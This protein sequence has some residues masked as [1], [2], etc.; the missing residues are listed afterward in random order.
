MSTRRPPRI[1]TGTPTRARP[2]L[3]LVD[4]TRPEGVFDPADDW[5]SP[6]ASP[7]VRHE[8]RLGRG[9][10][11]RPTLRYGVP[12][13]QLEA[14]LPPALN[15]LRRTAPLS[16]PDLTRVPQPQH[17]HVM[18]LVDQLQSTTVVRDIENHIQTVRAFERVMRLND[19]DPSA[20][21]GRPVAETHGS[22]GPTPGVSILAVLVGFALVM[23]YTGRC[24]KKDIAEI[25]VYGLPLES[26]QSLGIPTGPHPTGTDPR[27]AQPEWTLA[28][29]KAWQN[30]PYKQVCRAISRVVTALTYLGLTIPTRVLD[31]GVPR[32]MLKTER[33]ALLDSRTS[34]QLAIAAD[35]A[36]LL[37]RIGL[38]ITDLSQ[39]DDD[40]LRAMGADVGIDETSLESYA[41]FCPK[42]DPY[43]SSDPTMTNLYKDPTKMGYGVTAATIVATGDD[44][45]PIL[46]RSFVVHPSN[47]ASM[48]AAKIVLEHH[49]N[50][51]P[52]TRDGLAPGTSRPRWYGDKGYGQKTSAAH[53]ELLR[54]GAEGA[55]DL[56]PEQRVPRPFPAL[57]I[58]F[59]AGTAFCDAA[60]DSSRAQNFGPLSEHCSDTESK[61][62]DRDHDY[63][64]R[65][66]LTVI[67]DEIILDTDGR[68]SRRIRF[69]G[70]C[71]GTASGKLPRVACDRNAGSQ[72][73]L[74]HPRVLP[75]SPKQKPDKQ[76]PA[77]CRQ[78]TVTVHLDM[79][80]QL[81][82]NYLGHLYGDSKSQDNLRRARAATE[83]LF[84]V[85]KNQHSGPLDIPHSMR[86]MGEFTLYCAFAFA[87]HNRRALI[88]WRRLLQ[89]GDG[90]PP[91]VRNE[92]TTAEQLRRRASA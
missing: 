62:W 64:T 40:L 75:I 78:K 29:A 36:D 72:A 82:R 32:R 1:P 68:P 39:P 37:I 80:D 52:G 25:L 50:T 89:A 88:R 61:Q 26:R 65:R 19:P 90:K 5:D 60:E 9:G 18:A 11:T 58:T 91:R 73:W 79:D 4:D 54:A 49:L 28:D 21:P 51:H 41:G 24:T 2:T 48:P 16:P 35:S 38:T 81:E 23:R 70:P 57:G 27:T 30:G 86:G 3:R 42:S 67:S 43:V 31:D 44:R 74:D 69:S 85:G 53:L 46:A 83:G 7:S 12:T 22:P 71:Q 14:A 66:E 17:E 84:G 10:H 20:R 13:E 59:A 34:D 92:R 8:P 77:I 55:Y 33:Q 45:L 47:G 15:P 6:P 63:L 56:K 76:H 87:E